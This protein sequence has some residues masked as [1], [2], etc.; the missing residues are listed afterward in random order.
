MSTA[1]NHERADVRL[2]APGVRLLEV[3]GRDLFVGDTP[4]EGATVGDAR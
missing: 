3:V 1:E 4:Q 2:P